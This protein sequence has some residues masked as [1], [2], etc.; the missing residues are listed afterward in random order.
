MATEH[1]LEVGH[2]EILHVSGPLN[3]AEARARVEGWRLAMSEARLRPAELVR[4]DWSSGSGYDAGLRICE[5]PE[6]TA[7][8]VANDQMAIGVLRAL[9]ECGRR[10]PEDISVVGFDDVPEAAYLVPP[11]T[12]I[13]QDFE[14]IGRRA[15]EV[16][17]QA[18]KGEDHQ[19]S[20]SV[21]PKLVVRQST[22]PPTR[23]Q[24]MSDDK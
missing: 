24:Y 5:M 23:D 12:T 17:K 21:I 13:Q 6:T 18:I 8:F 1:L 14:A 7:V 2:R 15:I 19:P 3:W 20:P 4:G 10:V 9:H 22:A 16:I 11:L